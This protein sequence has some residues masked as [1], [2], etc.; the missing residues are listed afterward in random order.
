MPC[1]CTLRLIIFQGARDPYV[2]TGNG[3]GF[4][5]CWRNNVRWAI[6]QDDDP[7]KFMTV[8][9]EDY[10]L[11]IP[12]YSHQARDTS[13][14]LGRDGESS[15]TSSKRNTTMFKKV[16][17]KLSGN[18]RWLAGLMFERNLDQGGRSFV[19]V[20]HYNVLL[21]TP[22]HAKAAPGQVNLSIEASSHRA[23]AATGVRRFQRLPK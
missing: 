10:V 7:R 23:N 18:V 19:F 1:W 11:A 14:M 6:H 3:A 15:S 22:E 12:D 2:V 5:M 17:M 8:D 20:H 9:S 13:T 4:V 16:V 21:K